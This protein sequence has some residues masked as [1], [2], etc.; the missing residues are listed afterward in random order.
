MVLIGIE[1]STPEEFGATS[2]VDRRVRLC[3]QQRR[4]NLPEP[5]FRRVVLDRPRLSRATIICRPRAG[6]GAGI[7]KG[8]WIS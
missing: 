3:G 1:Y 8:T 5:V 7:Q 4:S 6:Q 2:D